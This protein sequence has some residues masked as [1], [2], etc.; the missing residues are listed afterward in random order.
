M[1]MLGFAVNHIIPQADLW[2]YSLST[3]IS[4][5][6]FSNCCKLNLNI[7]TTFCINPP[8]KA[9]NFKVVELF[10]DLGPI[11][12]SCTVLFAPDS[13][14]SAEVLG[15]N[16]FCLKFIA[17]LLAIMCNFPLVLGARRVSL[18]AGLG[19]SIADPE[20]TMGAKDTRPQEFSS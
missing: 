6:R 15:S 5:L 13:K 8:L 17:K 10:E 9:H 19:V 18:Y 2:R 7:L 14:S 16:T 20:G 4:K 12:L 11:F 1:W 3:L